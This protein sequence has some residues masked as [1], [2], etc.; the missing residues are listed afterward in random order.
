MSSTVSS[1]PLNLM[2]S[3]PKAKKTRVKVEYLDLLRK[4]EK[5]A[6]NYEREIFLKMRFIQVWNPLGIVGVITAFNFPCAVLGNTSLSY[7]L[8]DNCTA[9]DYPF[10]FSSFNLQTQ[11]YFCL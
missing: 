9:F 7:S 10:Q 8:Q 1:R 3:K 5:F 6:K 4:K 2:L 11:P